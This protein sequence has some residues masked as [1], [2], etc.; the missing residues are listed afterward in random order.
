M[1]HPTD[2]FTVTVQ[3][4]DSGT[5]RSVLQRADATFDARYAANVQ[6][7]V[8]MPRDAAE[9]V[10]ERLRSAT[11]DRVVIEERTD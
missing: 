1:A 9:E 5:V 3:Y 6:F 7:T 2:R 4:D 10:R 8:E 11:S